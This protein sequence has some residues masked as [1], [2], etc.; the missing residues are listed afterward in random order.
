[1]RHAQVC[2]Q[3]VYAPLLCARVQSAAANTVLH[4]TLCAVC[5][6]AS[7]RYDRCVALMYACAAMFTPF[8]QVVCV[9]HCIAVPADLVK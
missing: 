2:E 1:M 8:H 6:H 3:H 4:T 5:S 7:L 9:C